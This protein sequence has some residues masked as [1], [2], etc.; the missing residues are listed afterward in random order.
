MTDTILI[1]AHG[2]RD[3]DGNQEVLDFV[4]RWRTRHTEEKIEV[5]FIEFASPLVATG[6][7]QAAQGSSR[8]IAL[9]LILNAAGHV[10]LEIP[11][12]IRQARAKFPQTEFLYGR[13][14]GCEET[15]LKLLRMRLHSAMVSLDLPDPRNTGIL[16]LGRGASD[17]AANGEVAKMA[18]WIQESTRHDTV[19]YAFTGITQPRLEG[20]VQQMVKLGM[21]QIIVLPYYLFTGRLIKRIARQLQR[22]RLQYPQVAF[23]QANYLG[24]DETL[25]GLLDE[26]L[27]ET[28]GKREKSMMECDCCKFS[29]LAE[30]HGGHEA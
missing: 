10:K 6:L 2:S 27:E 26:R 19:E 11:G 17:M 12:L 3:Q 15:I 30:S 4:E 23:A 29:L 14:F 13:H 28:R 24:I 20:K 9:P 5:C 7:A 8:V 22:L 21:M 1:I 25:L 18:R 16:L